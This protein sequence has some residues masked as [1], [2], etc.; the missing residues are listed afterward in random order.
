MLNNII[1]PSLPVISPHWSSSFPSAPYATPRG[2]LSDTREGL[3]KTTKAQKLPENGEFRRIRTSPRSSQARALPPLVTPFKKQPVKQPGPS[4]FRRRNP[5]PPEAPRSS[6]GYEEQRG[7]LE[8]LQPR[9][10]NQRAEARMKVSVDA[11]TGGA[12]ASPRQAAVTLPPEPGRRGFLQTFKIKVR[13]VS[14]DEATTL[15]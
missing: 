7:G 13:S 15:I 8:T 14:A 2:P 12:A 1:Q 3:E 10:R 6:S 4:L 9:P 5:P 11:E